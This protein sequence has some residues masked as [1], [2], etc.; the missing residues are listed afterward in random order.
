MITDY[1]FQKEALMFWNINFVDHKLW[2]I[3]CYAKCC[4]HK[5]PGY[6][7]KQYWSGEATNKKNVSQ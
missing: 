7:Q 6:L 5:H 2:S 1:D 3:F 4:T